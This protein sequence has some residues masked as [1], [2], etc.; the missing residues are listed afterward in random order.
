MYGCGN[1]V[2]GWGVVV[3]VVVKRRE[4]EMRGEYFRN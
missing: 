2:D 3:V 4:R 1:V